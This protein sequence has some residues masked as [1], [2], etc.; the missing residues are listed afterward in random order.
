MKNFVYILAF[1]ITFST[2]TFAESK[3]ALKHENISELEKTLSSDFKKDF[4]Y[5]II[6]VPRGIILS[7]SDELLFETNHK[8]KNSAKNI[9]D[10]IGELLSKI[11]NNCTIEGH[12][13]DTAGISDWEYSMIKVD[14]LTEYLLNEFPQL[15][16][17]IFAVGF[18]SAEPFSTEMKF[19]N[20]S[21]MD[22]RVDFVFFEYEFTR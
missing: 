9:L 15:Q 17:K 13:S 12:S 18:G 10:I 20:N 4:N 1:L 21:K 2:K 5:T 6:E 19:E 3:N 11:S 14:T 22:N 8:I 16:N 7:I